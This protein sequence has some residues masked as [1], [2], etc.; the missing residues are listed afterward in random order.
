MRDDTEELYDIRDA[1]DRVFAHY[2][3]GTQIYERRLQ[4]RPNEVW[5][6]AIG[7]Q[8]ILVH[9]YFDIDAEIVLAVLENDLRPLREF[10]EPSFDKMRRQICADLPSSVY[11]FPPGS[12]LSPPRIQP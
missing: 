1:A 9:Q 3:R 12:S 8:N 5:R 2:R 11:C 4:S 10:L 6:K 7:L